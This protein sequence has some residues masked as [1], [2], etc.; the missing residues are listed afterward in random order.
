MIQHK[1]LAI[2]ELNACLTNLKHAKQN[3][4]ELG[5]V[6]HREIRLAIDEAI[7]KVMEIHNKLSRKTKSD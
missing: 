4:L 7:I 3:F 5:S 2:A 1:Q 6:H